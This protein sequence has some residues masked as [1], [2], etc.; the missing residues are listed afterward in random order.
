MQNINRRQDGMG[1][2]ER[3]VRLVKEI[4]RD[5]QDKE[6]RSS[7]CGM[8]ESASH[9]SLCLLFYPVYPV[10]PCLNLLLP[11]LMVQL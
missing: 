5:G 6:M 7:D 4:N 10:H 11:N 3:E 1:K 8:K 2:T 9:S